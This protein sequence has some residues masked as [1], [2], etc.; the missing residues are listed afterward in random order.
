MADV[1]RDVLVGLRDPTNADAMGFPRSQEGAGNEALRERE[2]A[3]IDSVT[4]RYVQFMRGRVVDGGALLARTA[5]VPAG[6]PVPVPPIFLDRAQKF[7]DRV[8]ACLQQAQDEALQWQREVMGQPP[9]QPAAWQPESLS[10][11]FSAN[12]PGELPEQEQKTQLVARD[13][14]NGDIDW[15]TFSA[16]GGQRDLWLDAPEIEKTPT[17]IALKGTSPRWWAFEDA[18]TDFGAVEA[19]HV[20]LPQLLFMDFVL[21]S[22]EDWF[23]IPVPAQVGQLVRVNSLKVIDTF[24]EEKI[25][26]SGR[27]P[28]ENPLQRFELFTIAD[29]DKPRDAGVGDFMLI[30]PVTGFRQESKPLEEIHF[31]RS[32]GANMLWGIEAFVR[33]GLGRSV[34]G[35]DAQRERIEID[36]ELDLA[37]LQDQLTTLE[38]QLDDP[39]LTDE[40]RLLRERQARELRGRIAG[41]TPHA[42]P[43]AAQGAVPRYQLAT[44][45]DK[46]WIPFV[47]MR[48]P[49]TVGPK[50]VAMQFVRAKMIR[51]TELGEPELIPAMSRLLAMGEDPLLNINEEAVPR[52]GVRLQ[53][54]KQRARWIDGTTHVWLG[55]KVLTGGG[56]AKGG[57]R[58]DVVIDENLL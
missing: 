32:E 22:G 26:P 38:A 52:S 39:Q 4:R 29:A 16:V 18:D 15:Y 53:L 13:Y 56:E 36:R 10:Y 24:G 14:R 55:R 28:T 11:R 44:R 54:T 25:I 49:E 40:Q 7:I 37:R 19:G 42:R 27:R 58:F 51:N 34:R 33:N 9:A 20:D 35:L 5:A 41:L 23:S 50:H 31:R 46:N 30:P 21:L 12:P 57:L 6:L 2:I 47:P 17:R 48:T 43:T 3:E 45:I 8:Q 1:V